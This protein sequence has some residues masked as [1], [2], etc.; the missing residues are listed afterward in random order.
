[1][2]LCDNCSNPN[3]KKCSEDYITKCSGYKENKMITHQQL[4]DQ[5]TPEFIKWCCEYAEGF[6]YDEDMFVFYNDRS[7]YVMDK[8]L[9]ITFLHRTVEGWNKQNGKVL[10]FDADRICRF[11]DLK[12]WT[13]WDYKS[14]TLTPCEMAIWHC[15]IELFKE[16]GK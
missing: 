13:F 3:K 8:F 9:F 16:V 15:L 1:M 5:T 12:N 2:S 11:T 6:S 14:G 4:K 7:Y 10:S